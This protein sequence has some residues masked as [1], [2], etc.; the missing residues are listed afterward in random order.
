M[1]DSGEILILEAGCALLALKKTIDFRISDVIGCI[2][3]HCHGDHAKYIPHYLKEGIKVFANVDSG[4]GSKSHNLFPVIGT[5]TI[6]GFTVKSF[7]VQHDVSNKGFLI[8]HAESGQVLFITDTNDIPFSFPDLRHAIVEANF[9]PELLEQNLMDGKIDIS[10]YRRVLQSHMSIVTLKDY[11]SANPMKQLVSITLIHPSSYNS[12]VKMFEREI[13][14]V[15]GTKVYIADKG[16]E[17][18]LNLNPF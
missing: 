9:S 5:F 2:S 6:G 8:S 3:T 17:V 14:A 1:A 4:P 11:F 15:S 16:L 18:D 10:V 13:K 12:D 7:D